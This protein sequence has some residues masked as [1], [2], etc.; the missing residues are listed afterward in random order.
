M[1]SH[2]TDSIRFAVG[3]VGNI[4]S[5][6][7]FLSPVPTFWRV[8]KNKSVE[9]FQFYPYVA[10][11]MNCL[12]WVFYGLPIIHP[13]SILIITI[14]GVGLVV[15]LVYL[16]IYFFYTDSKRKRVEIGGYLLIEILFLAVLGAPTLKLCHTHEER[17][18]II[19]IFC[20]VFGIVMY[21][22]PLTVMRKVIKTKS[23]EYMPFTLSLASFL[24]GLCWTAYALIEFDLFVLIANGVGALFGLSQLVLYAIYWWNGDK[25]KAAA[26]AKTSQVQLSQV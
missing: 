5:F 22:S 16:S 12:L 10:T 17:S 9:E 24:N 7:L 21:A 23:V 26:P 15:E 25:N 1:Y 8:L 20:V 3:I 2:T 11:V 14:N 19:G 4:L 13:N 6:G 18:R